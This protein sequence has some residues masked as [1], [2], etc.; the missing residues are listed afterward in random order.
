MRRR[1]SITFNSRPSTRP[2]G[3]DIKR[4]SGVERR[5][6]EGKKYPAEVFGDGLYLLSREGG[7]KSGS[8]Y[9][10]PDMNIGYNYC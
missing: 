1:S 9:Q 5:E 8:N 7:G 2:L 4:R 6:E 10:L 3:H